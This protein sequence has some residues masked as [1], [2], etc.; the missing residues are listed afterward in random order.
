MLDRD[1]VL[2][3]TERVL[4][5][6]GP[7]K[8][9]V[10]DV[11]RELGVSHAAVY[12]HFASKSDLREAVVR[13]W[14]GNARDELAEITRSAQPPADRLRSWLTA[15][16]E[17]KRAAVDEDSELFATFGLLAAESG[18]APSEHVADLL[19]QLTGI[20][21]DGV[22]S[23][24]FAAGDPEATARAVFDATAVFHHPAH[25]THWSRPGTEARLAAVCDLVLAGLRT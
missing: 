24:A 19:A 10:V 12:R 15:L 14:L 3:A 20:I 1:T 13:R 7:A 16:F 4:R 25:A 21:T 2:T 23:G 11:A 5:R 18:S 9:N 22:S 6:H 8:A 17:V